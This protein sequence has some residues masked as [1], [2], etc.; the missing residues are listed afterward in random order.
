[1]VIVAE[2]PLVVMQ[3][4]GYESS[5]RLS[6]DLPQRVRGSRAAMQVAVIAEVGISVM[7][8][9]DQ[10]RPIHFSSTRPAQQ[11]Q[12]TVIAKFSSVADAR[13]KHCLSCLQFCIC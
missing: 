11:P 2:Q 6:N 8:P 10:H 5:V 9:R 12:G 13:T 1:M 3:I 4:T 7:H